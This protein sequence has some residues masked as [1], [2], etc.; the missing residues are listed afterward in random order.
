M[1]LAGKV[2]LISGGTKGIGAATAV[3]FA[4]RGADVAIN[5]R[6]C[7]EQANKV[8]GE[9]EAMGRRCFVVT[10]DVS[11]PEEIERCVA[12]TE[13]SLGSPDVLIHSAG[14][15]APG[16]LLEVSAEVWYHAFDVH[17]HSVFHFCRA[18]VPLMKKKKEGA[19][20]LI[21][22]AAGLRG[23]LGAIAYGVVKGA[24]PQFARSLAR[25]L[26][27][28]NIRVNC[29]SPGIIRTRFQEYLTH[30]QV[31]NN[32]EKRV[33]LHR[34]GK[35]EDVAEVIATLVCNDFMTG[36]NIVIDGGMT[37]RIV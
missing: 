21:S 11:K 30:E 22:S 36:E 3:E 7:D 24:L 4:R 17:L 34:E 35:P 32:I 1:N 37:M 31:K 27:D 13:S 14:G 10:A 5:G 26:A 29:V 9:I 16:G 15:A 2:C 19:I 18:V 33:P 6:V 8:K 28:S 23:C 20:V 12:V 25:E